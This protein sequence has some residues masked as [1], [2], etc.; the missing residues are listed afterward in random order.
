MRKHQVRFFVLP[1]RLSPI[2]RPLSTRGQLHVVPSE[3]LMHTQYTLPLTMTVTVERARSL[4]EIPDRTT[5]EVEL[6]KLQ[7]R[8]GDRLVKHAIRKVRPG[9]R[10][11]YTLRYVMRDTDT[12]KLF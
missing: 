8:F 12:V 11:T 4:V 3:G 7:R 9:P 1:F 10:G 6:Q 5:A 2:T